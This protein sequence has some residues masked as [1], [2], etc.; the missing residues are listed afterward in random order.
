MAGKRITVTQEAES[1][2]NQKFHDNHTGEDMTRAQFVQKIE[3][4]LY[5]NYHVREIDGTKTPA[6]NPNYCFRSYLG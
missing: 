4:G 2:R 3:S 5:P 6:S 1:G